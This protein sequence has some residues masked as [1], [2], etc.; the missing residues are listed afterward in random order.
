[1]E[2]EGSV[3]LMT[4]LTAR[5]YL[6]AYYDLRGPKDSQDLLALL[7]KFNVW[8][9]IPVATLR[10]TWPEGEWE[11]PEYVQGRQDE[12]TVP[13]LEKSEIT[14][15]GNS[16]SLRDGAMATVIEALLDESNDTTSLLSEAEMLTDFLPKLKEKFYEQSSSLKLSSHLQDLLFRALEKDTD[17]DLSPFTSFS[18]EDLSLVVS[19]LRKYGNM[20]TLCISNR[21]DLTAEDL[22]VVLRD[23]AG[24]K[25]LYILEDP[26][27]T[28]HDISPYLKDCDLF[29]SDLLRQAIKPPPEDAWSH[30]SSSK[31]DE[32]KPTTQVYGEN[33][34]SQLV[35]IGITD[36]QALDKALRLKNGCID[37]KSLQQ[38]KSQSS[39][40]W[41]GTGLRYKRYALDL[42]LTTLR[43]VAGLQRLLKWGAAAHLYDVEQFAKGAAFSF[44]T[45]SSI[46]GGTELEISAISG[47][48]EVGI[49]ATSGGN[50]LGIKPT[51]DSSGYGIGPLAL[52]LYRGNFYERIPK[53]D[54]QEH[55]ESGR[56][57]IV[58]VHEAY[59]AMNQ[60]SLDEWQQGP[61]EAGSDDEDD[62]IL[63]QPKGGEQ[64]LQGF[65]A[66][67]LGPRDPFENKSKNQ[68]LPFRAIKRLRYA[69]VT[70]Y[71]EPNP[72]NHDFMVA[73]I[74]T[75]LEHIM[76]KNH[77][78]YQKWVD[79]WNSAIAA[80]DAADFYGDED[81][82]DFLPKVFPGQKIASSGSKPE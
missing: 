49:S 31:S 70:P 81:I 58:F 54:A 47:R 55:L 57:A 65:M 32:A 71:I 5:I 6:E 62:N 3:Q 20:Q 42:P 12:V 18:A 45:K 74:P 44:A 13:E 51:T 1:M 33:D 82:H 17:V 63:G 53:V 66:M 79:A 16:K 26:Q 7:D 68:N 80:I 35:W 19:R 76:G 48:N 28:A 77:G 59:N 14:D 9:T 61:N 67:L 64:S 25:A 34:V 8:D 36:Q 23:A 75:Y 60:K 29:S 52:G 15:P 78:D 30:R 10:D 37:W 46:L 4:P 41:S 11:E 2:S 22:Q 72:S 50:G 24:L 40:G 73:D 56:W 21:P 27:I 38:E 39:W 43:T 69:L